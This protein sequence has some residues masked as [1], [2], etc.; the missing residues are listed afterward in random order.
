MSES[1]FDFIGAVWSELPDEDRALFQVL[2]QGYEQVF[3]SAYQRYVEVTLNSAIEDLAAYST[4]RWIP[5][6][7]LSSNAVPLPAK[8]VSTQDISQ[9]VNL[10]RRNELRISL[11]GGEPVDITL[12][13]ANT[14]KVTADE[15]TSAI[16]AA[17]GLQVATALFSGA[18]IQ[19]TSPTVGSQGKIKF[20]PTSNPEKNA[21]EFVMGISPE[22]TPFTVSGNDF[23]F[24]LPYP[25]I[26][27]IPALQDKI[28]EDFVGLVLKEGEDYTV[29]GGVIAFKAAPPEKLWAQRTLV[30][31][32]VPWSNFGFLVDIYQANSPRY[33]EI[34]RGI[35][36]ALWTG[37]RP[38]NVETSL[39]LILGLPTA[40]EDS[41]V[42]SVTDEQIVTKSAAGVERTFK[43]PTGLSPK[44]A[45]GQAVKQFQPLTT[46]VKIFDKI[47]DPGFLQREVGRAGIKH[48]LTEEA[49][50]G[51]GSWTDE[52]KALTALEEFT[53][54]PQI[55]SDAFIYPDVSLKNIKKFLDAIKPLNKAYVFQILGGVF[56]EGVAVTDAWAYRQE[57]D[58][59]ETLDSNQ[60]TMLSGLILSDYEE[61][62]YVDLNL[63]PHGIL[64]E[65]K[66]EFEVT[67]LGS[68]SE[69]FVI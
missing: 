14:Y 25:R 16:N 9:G 30:N 15:I 51:E 55:S 43:V 39:C 34:L 17:L 23:A 54:L 62:N 47:N 3:A 45:L 19:L 58:L 46:G 65:E 52:T 29:S 12:A 27:S 57:I 2:W 61:N 31:R 5:Y 68:A 26:V 10:T 42:T 13:A 7:F 33:V 40:K 69:V 38:S 11:D 67:S 44:V 56:S 22:S 24:Q 6:S 1:Y 36:Y 35:W 18:L 32:E 49:S 66:V 63:D 28:G 37:P 8:I 4:D 59:A 48:F 64:F 60:T 53:F 20:Y 41:E 21:C 50:K